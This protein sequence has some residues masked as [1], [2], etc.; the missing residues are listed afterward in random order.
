MYVLFFR[1]IIK[2]SYLIKI[3]VEF[4]LGKN[5]FFFI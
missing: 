1:K 2:I 4:K 3:K 5:P